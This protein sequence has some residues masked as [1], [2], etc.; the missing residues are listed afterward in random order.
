MKTD[1][2]LVNKSSVC[3]THSG[4][5]TNIYGQKKHKRKRKKGMRVGGMEERKGKRKRKE[6]G[7]KKRKHE[8]K[9]L[10]PLTQYP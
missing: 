3:L 2:L 9:L 4:N 6:S 5:S 1:T 10:S 8:N 7:G